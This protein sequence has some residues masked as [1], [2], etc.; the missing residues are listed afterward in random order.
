MRVRARAKTISE[1]TPGTSHHG[2]F[3]IRSHA[4]KAKH[5]AISPSAA[6]TYQAIDFIGQARRQTTEQFGGAS[7]EFLHYKAL[8]P[9]LLFDAVDDTVPLAGGKP[10]LVP[11]RHRGVLGMPT[12]SDHLPH[13]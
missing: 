9:R 5:P 12:V 10:E 2:L 8:S 3:C 7:A 1:T 6:I 4:Q 11:G 13:T